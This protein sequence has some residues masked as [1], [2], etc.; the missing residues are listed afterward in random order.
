MRFGHFL[1]ITSNKRFQAHLRNF[2]NWKKTQ[3]EPEP[4]PD[5]FLFLIKKS[6]MYNFYLI[7]PLCRLFHFFAIF[8]VKY[9]LNFKLT[10]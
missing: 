5:I 3:P 9:K 1:T 6:K 4:E 10:F 7:F 8:L 2:P